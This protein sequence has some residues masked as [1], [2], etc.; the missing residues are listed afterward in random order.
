MRVEI[1]ENVGIDRSDWSFFLR[2][3]NEVD[4]TERLE[5]GNFEHCTIVKHGLPPTMFASSYSPKTSRV[6]RSVPLRIV[7]SSKEELKELPSTWIEVLTR[8]DR[9]KVDQRLLKV[10]E[11]GNSSL[12][13]LRR[14][15]RPT[16]DRSTPSI[17]IFPSVASTNRKKDKARVLFPEPVLPRI[18]IYHPPSF[19][20]SKF[21]QTSQTPNVLTFSP[22]LTSNVRP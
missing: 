6:E 17:K 1:T 3:W 2:T 20:E 13:R 7:G 21:S 18:P 10:K 11:R 12:N 14:S 16:L 9:C 15:V 19:R 4:T 22:G 8:D 5:L